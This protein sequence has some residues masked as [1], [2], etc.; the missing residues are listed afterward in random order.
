MRGLS[1]STGRSRAFPLPPSSGRVALRGRELSSL[2]TTW[3]GVRSP[4]RVLTIDG[5]VPRMA[6]SRLCEV[7]VGLP[8]LTRLTCS[9]F[10]TPA[11]S[12]CPWTRCASATTD[13]LASGAPLRGPTPGR[14]LGAP[15]CRLSP[16][17]PSGP[18]CL[19]ACLPLSVL[20][21][22]RCRGAS[23]SRYHRL[24]PRGLEAGPAHPRNDFT[25]DGCT[26][27]DEK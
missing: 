27:P 20:P 3:E 9:A 23:G 10:P 4:P 14:G 24:C 15:G 26:A 25:Q 18:V 7:G 11:E 22:L 21:V 19:G 1:Q 8:P 12:S 13:T 6:C 2:P 5:C 16:P 17:P